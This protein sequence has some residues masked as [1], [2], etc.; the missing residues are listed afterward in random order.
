MQAWADSV[1]NT[2]SL[3]E[4]VGQLFFVRANQPNQPYLDEVEKYI[5]EYNIGGIV[6]FAG[7]PVSQVEQTNRWNKLA[8][9]PLF[10]SIDAEWGLGMRLKNTIS[11]P[12]QMTLGAIPDNNQL[13]LM[14]SQVGQQ[15]KRMGIQINF[16]PVVDINNNPDNP[17]IGMRSFGE[18]PIAVSNKGFSYMKGMQDVGII[19]CAKHFPGHGNTVADSHITL[20]LV[21]ASRKSLEETE[22]VPFQYLID[23]GVHSIMVAHL[24]IPAMEDEN[25]RPSSLSEKI[26]TKKLKKDM[27]FKGLI[28]TDGLDMKGVTQ[29]FGKGEVALEALKAGDDVLLIPEDIPASVE[30][31]LKALENEEISMERVEESCKK[32]LKY[33]YLSGAW[34]G[35]VIDTTNLIKD[36]NKPIYSETMKNLF[37]DA[38]TLVKNDNFLI[39]V[40]QN[41]TLKTAL[42]IL[43]SKSTTEFEITLKNTIPI[44]VFHLEHSANVEE[45]QKVINQLAGFNLAIIAIVN[46]NILAGKQ[47]GITDSDIQFVDFVARSKPVILNIFASPYTLN[48]F[49]SI[50]EIES[51]VISYQDKT[52]VQKAS[53]EIILGNQTAGGLL[54]VSAG[55]YSAG[56]GLAS[57]KSRLTYGKPAELGIDTNILK[58]VD[59]IALRGI[60]MNAYP[61]CQI[62]AAKDGVIF[63]EK[64]FGYQTYENLIPINNSS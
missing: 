59:S 57:K 3:K 60:E 43:G 19:A 46:T 28:I 31:I 29:H 38:I 1:Y 9:T 12:L 11:Y 45:K 18:N 58:K 22:L 54:P 49:D 44:T 16:A 4:K 51:I 47:F 56:S 6:F 42:I 21:G 23:Q 40:S 53:A 25:N 7:N 26:I 64:S 24:S 5:K 37:A 15:C 27:G 39:P 55:G 10:I 41:D 30:A 35:S 13:Y 48:L 2:L 50:D 20:P 14:G 62:L 52:V 34:K 33:K 63:Y 36:L 8:K 32:I 17:V 61:G